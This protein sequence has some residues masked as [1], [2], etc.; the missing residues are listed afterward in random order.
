MRHASP[1][2]VVFLTTTP[3][4]V[5]PMARVSRSS[6]HDL[7]PVPWP[8]EP[9]YAATIVSLQKTLSSFVIVKVGVLAHRGGNAR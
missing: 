2:E 1:R 4:F 6:V 9:R 7:L 8:V 3:V 5:I